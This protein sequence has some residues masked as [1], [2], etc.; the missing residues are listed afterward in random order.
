[1]IIKIILIVVI[2]IIKMNNK[3]QLFN[4]IFDI[5][6]EE[7]DIFI[8]PIKT[9]FWKKDSD[10]ESSFDIKNKIPFEVGMDLRPIIEM[11]YDCGK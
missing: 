4:L 6:K 3:I 10:Y 8:F 5:G 2:L 9:I 1:M 11:Y 7:I